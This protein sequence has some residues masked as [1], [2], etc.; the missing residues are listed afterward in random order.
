M[1]THVLVGARERRK[2]QGY[3]GLTGSCS[4][5]GCQCALLWLHS[6]PRACT[7][8]WGTVIRIRLGAC[9]C[10]AG[11][12]SPEHTHSAGV[13]CMGVGQ[14][15]TFVQPQSLGLS[16]IAVLRLCGQK[17]KVETDSGVNKHKYLWAKHWKNL[18]GAHSS[19]PGC[20]FLPWQN[21]L[22]LSA[23]QVTVNHNCS[24]SMAAIGSSCFSSLFLVVSIHLSFAGLSWVKLK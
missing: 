1:Q 16:A 23:G 14:G 13:V 19:C 20:L 11:E 15:L 24:H 2:G 17:E 22:G 10:T 18:Q 9:R 3:Y 12:V 4:I 21:V 8:S 7:C 5:P 6:V